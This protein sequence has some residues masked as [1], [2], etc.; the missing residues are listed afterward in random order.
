MNRLGEKTCSGSSLIS[1]G[2]ENR[3]SSRK[4][5]F[6]RESESV[7]S[8]SARIHRAV[9]VGL[10]GHPFYPSFFLRQPAPF[11]RSSMFPNA[12][13]ALSMLPSSPHSLGYYTDGRS[14]IFHEASSRSRR[15]VARLPR[16]ST[17]RSGVAAG[18]Q[19]RSNPDAAPGTPETHYGFIVRH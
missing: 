1:E 8:F 15:F 11:L 9:R 4:Q 2:Y 13:R 6:P 12:K 19:T 17:A 18:P 5:H 7:V 10:S 3:S 16:L 14:T